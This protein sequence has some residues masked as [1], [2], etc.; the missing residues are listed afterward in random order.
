VRLGPEA[1]AF[2]A[3][4]LRQLADEV[5][6]CRTVLQE[7]ALRRREHEGRDRPWLDADDALQAVDDARRA[8][9]RLV[10]QRD[11][12]RVRLRVDDGARGQQRELEPRLVAEDREL[13]VWRALDDLIG[14]SA[15][16]A[17][18]VFAQGLTLDLLIVEANRRL[19]ELARRYRLEKS[20]G[21]ELDFVVVDL[22]MG[23]A[24]RALQTLSGGETF[25]VSLALALALA[26]LAAPRARVETLFLDEGFGTLD[27]HNLEV[28]I[29]ALDSL[30]ATGCQV[31]VISHVDGF[32]E[33][34]GAVIE[35]RPEGSGQSRVL[36]PTR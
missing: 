11:E 12:V 30:Q 22:D 4:E 5:M 23:G 29:G 2:E 24:R 13:S 6:R 17:F 1:L 20:R 19:L 16:D 28:A 14:S 26:T 10:E 15:G 7:R 36:A 3:A 25:L 21:G 18:A 31:G 8:R 9:E 32:A 35:V 33:R 34:I 27:A